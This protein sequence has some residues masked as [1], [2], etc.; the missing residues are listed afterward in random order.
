[1]EQKETNAKLG[2]TEEETNAA[3]VQGREAIES[4]FEPG[5]AVE[6]AFLWGVFDSIAMVIAD[7]GLEEAFNYSLEW[8]KKRRD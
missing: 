5:Q 4:L 8:A 1:M 6:K 7:C 3:Y 2:L